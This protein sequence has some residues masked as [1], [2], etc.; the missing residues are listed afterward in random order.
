MIQD[1]ARS[2]FRGW[3]QEK[4]FQQNA[5]DAFK[6][7]LAAVLCLWAGHLLGLAHSYWAAISAIVVMASDT[8]VTVTS[9]RD[10]LIG[11]AIGALL[12]WATAY[13]WHG[14][15]VLYGIS[16]AIAVFACSLL[17]FEKAGRLAAVALSIVV[18]IYSGDH[19]GRAALSRFFEVGLGIVVAMAVTLLVFP[20]RPPIKGPAIK[21]SC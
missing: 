13:Y 10:R 2:F 15:F 19:P 18:L 14:H 4:K 20:A 11:T 16:V 7:G 21:D 17:Q 9:C 5:T 6:T 1:T 3:W 8:T 12:G